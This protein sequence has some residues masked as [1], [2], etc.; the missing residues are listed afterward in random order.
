[1]WTWW[2]W[3]PL[4]ARFPAIVQPASF[5]HFNFFCMSPYNSKVE[6]E[7][8]VCSCCFDFD[9]DRLP[10]ES[11]FDR[12]SREIFA[13]TSVVAA[14]ES[15]CKRCRVLLLAVEPYTKRT[16][17]G[18]FY[19]SLFS[20]DNTFTCCTYKD[21]GRVNAIESFEIFAPTAEEFS[22]SPRDHNPVFYTG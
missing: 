21:D 10:S 8:D 16:G 6:G 18:Q 11:Q 9:I 12:L 15:G 13:F 20:L 2:G 22:S 1:M 7:V 17:V 4:L 3:G 14:A 19:L 5:L